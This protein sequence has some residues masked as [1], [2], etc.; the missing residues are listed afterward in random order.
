V[1]PQSQH[2]RSTRGPAAGTAGWYLELAA[3]PQTGHLLVTLKT[4]NVRVDTPRLCPVQSP[5]NRNGHTIRH[6][7]AQ[8]RPSRYGW[9]A[10]AAVTHPEFPV[11]N[12]IVVAL[13]LAQDR[14]RGREILEGWETGDHLRVW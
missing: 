1:N 3:P 7:R 12:H 6:N 11:A 2:F 9:S 8:G 4:L 5:A 14:G 13:D 10:P